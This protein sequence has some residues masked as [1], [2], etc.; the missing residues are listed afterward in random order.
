MPA[1]STYLSDLGFKVYR[2]LC[3]KL[4]EGDRRHTKSRLV[5]DALLEYAKNNHPEIHDDVME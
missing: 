5:E 2:R 3:D 1:I 4:K